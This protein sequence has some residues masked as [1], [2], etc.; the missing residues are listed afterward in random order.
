[1]VGPG[2]L[3]SV[4]DVVCLLNEERTYW[5]GVNDDAAIA[6]IG[7]IG[8]LSNCIV[9]LLGIRCAPW[10]T[11]VTFVDDPRAVKA[12]ENSGDKSPSS[13]FRCKSGSWEIVDGRGLTVARDL[14]QRVMDSIGFDRCCPEAEKARLAIAAVINRYM[15]DAAR[16]GR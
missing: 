8:A 16:D 6:S 5:E 9:T 10:H 14:S 2:K 7:A 11:S 12:S 13:V 1:M 4:D 3:V 15:D